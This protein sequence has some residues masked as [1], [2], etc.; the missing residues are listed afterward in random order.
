MDTHSYYGML[1]VIA[2]NVVFASVVNVVTY[3]QVDT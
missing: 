3:C 2:V 1:N